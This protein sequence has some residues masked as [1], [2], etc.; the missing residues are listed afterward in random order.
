[1][2]RLLYD[3]MRKVMWY[4]KVVTDSSH[5]ESHAIVPKD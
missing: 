2:K 3:Q 4:G 1:M 5:G